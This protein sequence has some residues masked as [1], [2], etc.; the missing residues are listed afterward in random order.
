M[1]IAI[2]GTGHVGKAM[3]DFFSDH[4]DIITYDIGKDATYPKKAVDSCDAV[5]ICVSTPMMDDG[6]CDISNV[7]SAIS[8]ID[9]DHIL[10]KST[11]APGTTQYLSK[12]YNKNI[13]FSPEYI[14][15]ST[16]NNNIYRTMKDVPFLIIGGEHSEVMHFFELFE[17]VL[18]PQ[19]TYYECD[20]IDAELIK[21]MENSF[22]ATKVTFVNE[23][24]EIAKAFDANWHR[25]REGWLLDERIGRPFT[26]VFKDKRGFSGKCLPK[27]TNAIAVA[28]RKA[29]Y[30]PDFIS[31]VISTN[32]RIR[33]IYDDESE[34]V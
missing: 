33:N 17:R 12:K 5:L 26:T 6:S 7:E 9:N 10:I 18:G 31:E 28:A 29:G 19:A 27:D 1:K 25:V 16:Y 2:I 11:V 3:Y 14:G 24:Y 22:L 4:A 8:K 21:Y 15:E 32:D 30:E 34:K 20:S 23:F 13:C